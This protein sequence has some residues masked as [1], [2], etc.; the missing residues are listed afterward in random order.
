MK[1]EWNGMKSNRM[2]EER[3]QIERMEMKWNGMEG[4]KWNGMEIEWKNGMK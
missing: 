3:K 4:K 2:E 1:K